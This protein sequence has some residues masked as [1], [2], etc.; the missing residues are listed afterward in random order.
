[1]KKVFSALMGILL[2]GSVAFGQSTKPAE[3]KMTPPKAT[4]TKNVSAKA[5][6]PGDVATPAPTGARMKKDGTPDMRYKENQRLK[7]DGAPDMR[8]KANKA[9]AK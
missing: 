3:K 9:K 1:M 6:T 5:A 7:K 8:Y 4:A 2:M